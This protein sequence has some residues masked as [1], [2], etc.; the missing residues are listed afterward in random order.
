MR[1]FDPDTA[2]QAS[3]SVTIGAASGAKNLS[4]Y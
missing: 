1:P 4:L 3:G 2:P